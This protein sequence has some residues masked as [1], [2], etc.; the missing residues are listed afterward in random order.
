M[1]ADRI[2]AAADTLMPLVEAI[3]AHVF[4][5]ERI[6]ADDITV[7]VLAKG[8]TRTGRLWTYVREPAPIR[9]Q[10]CS[11]ILAIVAASIPSSIWQASPD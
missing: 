7:P 6:H 11:S 8:K 10:R 9:R 1:L 2:G 3:R 5:A 4:A